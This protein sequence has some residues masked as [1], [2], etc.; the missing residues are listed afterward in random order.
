MYE[1]S[2]TDDWQIHYTDNPYPEEPAPTKDTCQA[3][4]EN[5]PE[6]PHTGSCE[7]A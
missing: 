2:F 4:Y 5:D 3:C 6:V 7:L 1:I